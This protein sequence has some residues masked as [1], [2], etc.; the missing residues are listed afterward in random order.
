[1]AAVTREIVKTTCLPV[2]VN[3]LRND[4]GAAMA[5]ATATE[6]QFIR[7]NVHMHTVGWRNTVS[8]FSPMRYKPSA[9]CSLRDRSACPRPRTDGEALFRQAVGFKLARGEI[10]T[11]YNATIYRDGGNPA[12]AVAILPGAWIRHV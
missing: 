3:A 8:K 4:A 7:V 12:P 2:G 5:I 9:T 11:E 10:G 1:M 6:A